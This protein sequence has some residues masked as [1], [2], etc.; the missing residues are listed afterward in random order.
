MKNKKY[1]KYQD[2]ASK[3]QE[4]ISVE[5]LISLFNLKAALERKENR[6]NRRINK[7]L[8]SK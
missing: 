3:I 1:T 8:H 4:L 7:K 6:I 2:C 5:E